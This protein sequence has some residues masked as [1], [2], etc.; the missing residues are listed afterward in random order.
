MHGVLRKLGVDDENLESFVSQV[1]QRSQSKGIT[2]QAIV[3]CSQQILTMADK[4]PI[5]RI[6]QHIQ[7]MIEEKQELE[8]ELK[9]LR[10]DVATA[11]EEREEALK[12]SQTTIRNIS[13]FVGLKEMLSKSGLSIDNFA[14]INKMAK[15]LYNVKKCSYE[16]PDNCD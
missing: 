3:E 8:Q 11:K 2:P 5:T 9:I 16:P 7:T 1:Y 10:N 12:K 13:E 15:V 4:I 6:P 14:E